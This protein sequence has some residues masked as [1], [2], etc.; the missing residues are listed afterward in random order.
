MYH[1][2][3]CQNYRVKRLNHLYYVIAVIYFV[4]VVVVEIAD[5]LRR[6]L[7][8]RESIFVTIFIRMRRLQPLCR[9]HT[10]QHC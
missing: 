2:L 6:R 7:A 8:S 9:A 5:K 3:R 1:I 4:I 10:Q